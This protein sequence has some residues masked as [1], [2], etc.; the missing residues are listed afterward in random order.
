MDYRKKDE[1]LDEIYR[2]INLLLEEFS[3]SPSIFNVRLEKLRDL[4]DEYLEDPMTGEEE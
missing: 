1:Q 4:I 3:E 2:Q